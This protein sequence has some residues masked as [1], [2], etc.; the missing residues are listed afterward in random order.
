M[1]ANFGYELDLN[2][3]SQQELDVVKTQIALYKEI[4][5]TIQN[6]TLYRIKN[7]FNGNLAQWNFVSRTGNR[8]WRST[9]RY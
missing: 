5:D 4:R 8:W 3:L 2:A 6:G 9:S 1:S 7:P